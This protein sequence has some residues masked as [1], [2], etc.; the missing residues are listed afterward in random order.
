MIQCF[1]LSLTDC[2]L[3]E[4]PRRVLL[5]WVFFDRQLSGSLREEDVQNILLSLGLYLTTA[6]VS[7]S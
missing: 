3:K 1:A 6:Q 2:P 4:L 7:F 5:S